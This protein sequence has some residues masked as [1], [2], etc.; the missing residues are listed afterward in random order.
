MQLWMMLSVGG[1]AA[2]SCHHSFSTH[3]LRT[4]SVPSSMLGAGGAVSGVH[5]WASK[6]APRERECG[7]G[8]RP[9]GQG[10]EW[11]QDVQVG[12]KHFVFNFVIA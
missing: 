4:S 2:A 9:Q 8:L 5:Y 7:P 3:S 1:K 6:G 12:V 10:S 11:R